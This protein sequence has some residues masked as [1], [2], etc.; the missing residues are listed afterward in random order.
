MEHKKWEKFLD[1]CLIVKIDSQEKQFS[2]FFSLNICVKHSVWV[3]SFLDVKCLIYRVDLRGRKLKKAPCRDGYLPKSFFYC[4]QKKLLIWEKLLMEIFFLKS[5]K[6]VACLVKIRA[7]PLLNHKYPKNETST[8]FLGKIIDS[9]RQFQIFTE[10]F[11][12][13]NYEICV[14]GVLE[15]VLLLFQR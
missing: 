1:R 5:K 6:S 10:I 14:N 15:L 11:L 12:L 9:I 8:D 4:H 7:R 2:V 13:H 3:H